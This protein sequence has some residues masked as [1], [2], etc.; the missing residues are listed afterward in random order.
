MPQ[1]SSLL[2]G[3][4]VALLVALLILPGAARADTLAEY[5]LKA[6]FLL[7]FVTF[8]EWPAGVGNALN[9]CIFGP[10]PFGDNLDK[11]QGKSVAGRILVVRRT[12][13]VS[14][15]A[16]CQVVFIT[17]LVSGSLPRVLDYLDGK[18]VLT[19]ADTP[20]AARQGV[21]LNMDTEQSKVTFE[22]NLGAARG[23]GL[24]LSSKLLRLA[25][26]VYQ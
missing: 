20:G 19:I 24:G 23:N 12:N 25:R 2:G 17:R 4:R 1:S 8:T 15:L 21:A 5:R 10:D 11:L 6:A 14:S 26:E 9:L 18:P 3:W 16:D 7:N 13:S 22:A